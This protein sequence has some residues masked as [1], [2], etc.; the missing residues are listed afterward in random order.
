MIKLLA[1]GAALVAALSLTACDPVDNG[2]TTYTPPATR[3][4][5]GV[6]VFVTPKGPTV[7]IDLG[8]GMHLN[9][10]TG[11]IGFGVPVG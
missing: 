8:G 4:P 11:G 6:G 5:G 3:D 7:G 9:P 10:A 2:G 1:A